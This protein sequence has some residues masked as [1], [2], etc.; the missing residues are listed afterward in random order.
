MSGGGYGAFLRFPEGN[1]P[2]W[3]MLFTIQNPF[4]EWQ[5]AE[6]KIGFVLSAG[7]AVEIGVGRV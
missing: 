3:G 1:Q 2:T 6:R 7:H 4:N 5:Y